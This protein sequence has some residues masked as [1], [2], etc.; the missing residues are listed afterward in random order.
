MPMRFV[1]FDS[2]AETAAALAESLLAFLSN[3]PDA[4]LALPSG[5]T[6]LPLYAILAGAVAEGRA[7][8]GRA[9]VFALDELGGLGAEDPRSFARYFRTHVFGPLG[10]APER[11]HVMDGAAADPEAE[12]RRYEEAIRAAGGLDLAVLGIGENGHIAFNEPAA[13][14]RVESGVVKLQ[15][16]N[17][18]IAPTGLSMGV[19][20]ILGAGTVWLTATGA[21]KAAA[22]A[23]MANGLIDPACPASFLAVHP[24]ATIFLDAEASARL[25]V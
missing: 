2:P 13:A 7:D 4:V 16:P 21:S 6:P 12:C 10:V 15:P 22:V 20:T 8:F 11:A 5:N 1:R 19:G 14:L 18:R 24:D 3:C 17:D 23:R 9:T 25:R